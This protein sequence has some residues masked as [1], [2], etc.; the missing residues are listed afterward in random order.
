MITHCMWVSNYHT[1]PHKY[2]Q[3]SCQLKINYEF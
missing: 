2:A 1:V 3:L